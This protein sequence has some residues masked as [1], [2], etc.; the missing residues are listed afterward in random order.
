[1]PRRDAAANTAAC[2]A[3]SGA[4]DT[5]N[6]IFLEQLRGIRA[7]HVLLQEYDRQ[8]IAV[9][10]ERR[11]AIQDTKLTELS[12]SDEVSGCSGKELEDLRNRAQEEMLSLRSFLNDFNRALRTDPPGVFIDEP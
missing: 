3:L 11:K 8:M 6:R 7:Q 12:V 5:Q 1:M 10:L 2:K 4:L 9:I